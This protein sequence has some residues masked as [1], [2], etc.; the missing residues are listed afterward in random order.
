MIDDKKIEDATEEIFEDKFIGCGEMVD[1]GDIKEAIALGIKLGIKLGINEFLRDL[2]HPASEE[3]DVRHKT[4]IC[5]YEDGHICQDYDAY[6][7]ATESDKLG[8]K[9]FKWNYYAE[10]NEI[11]KWC[12]ATDLLPKKGGEQ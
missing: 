9:E 4:I 6:D 11:K 7:E 2:W 3:P 1:E 10:D 5:L 8:R 12:Y